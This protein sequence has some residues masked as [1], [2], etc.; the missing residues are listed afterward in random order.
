MATKK[1]RK[2]KRRDTETDAE[3]RL[4][5]TLKKMGLV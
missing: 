5:K 4:F 2:V 1:T 3:K